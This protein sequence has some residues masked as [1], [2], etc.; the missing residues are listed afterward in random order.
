MESNFEGFIMNVLPTPD[1]NRQ[2][3]TH[4]ILWCTCT[5]S[6][7]VCISQRNIGVGCH[8][9]LPPHFGVLFDQHHST[10]ALLQHRMCGCKVGQQHPE[11]TFAA[12]HVH[13]IHYNGCTTTGKIVFEVFQQRCER[14]N[15]LFYLV[16]KRLSV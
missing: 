9:V 4:P 8:D 11:E 10:Y 13:H 15:G 3:C 12:A 2:C 16:Q 14:D 7:T 1:D 6:S 5:C